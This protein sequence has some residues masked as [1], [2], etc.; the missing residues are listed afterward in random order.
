AAYSLAVRVDSFFLPLL[1]VAFLQLTRLLAPR[2]QR[3][4]NCAGLLIG[5]AAGANYPGALLVAWLVV[6]R[7][8]QPP[9]PAGHPAPRL[10]RP[11]ALA[12]LAFLVTNPY[13][14]V[15]PHS[16]VQHLAFLS[17]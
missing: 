12:A 11:L 8:L 10:W 1:L 15:H 4:W 17:G 9:A 7:W 6:A 3:D 14:L 5:L 13:V 2:P 16:F